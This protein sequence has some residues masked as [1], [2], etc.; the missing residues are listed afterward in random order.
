V[1]PLFFEETFTVEDYPRLLTQFTSLLKRINGV[2]GLARRA[3]T[4]NITA[5]FLQ[6]FFGV[7]ISRGLG[8]HDH[9]TS[10]HLTTSFWWDFLKTGSVAITQEAR[11]TLNVTV[12]SCCRTLTNKL[13]KKLQDT[14]NGVNACLRGGG[15]NCQLLL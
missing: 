8:H 14:A 3:R 6:K 13:L 10:R 2:S 4:A 5:A 15:G 7:L 9:Q 1:G 12:Q 11:R